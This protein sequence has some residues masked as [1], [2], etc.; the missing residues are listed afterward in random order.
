[1][2]IKLRRCLNRESLGYKVE[3]AEDIYPIASL[4]IANRFSYS[5]SYASA[6]NRIPP[7]GIGGV[8]PSAS[9][10]LLSIHPSATRFLRLAET[11]RA[12]RINAPRICCIWQMHLEDGTDEEA[13]RESSSPPPPLLPIVLFAPSILL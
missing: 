9:V 4:E 6:R 5:R 1:M 8:A 10:A 13:S 12:A 7:I 3:R 11:R 2:Q